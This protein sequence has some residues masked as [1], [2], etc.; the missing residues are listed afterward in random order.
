MTELAFAHCPL[1]QQKYYLNFKKNIPIGMNLRMYTG[2]SCRVKGNFGTK[3]TQSIISI[4]YFANDIIIY[5]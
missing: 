4:I 1:F 3:N 2:V 5:G